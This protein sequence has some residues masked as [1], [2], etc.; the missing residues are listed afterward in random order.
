MERIANPYGMT[1]YK[2]KRVDQKIVSNK[3]P[4]P[5]GWCLC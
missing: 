5:A 2:V 4:E 1:I 3:E